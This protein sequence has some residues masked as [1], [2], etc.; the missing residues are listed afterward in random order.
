LP[1]GSFAAGWALGLV[2]PWRAQRARSHVGILLLPISSQ[3]LK[4][5][6]GS[7]MQ[8]WPADG[9]SPI[10]VPVALRRRVPGTGR[11]PASKFQTGKTGWPSPARECVHHSC[12]VARAPVDLRGIRRQPGLMFERV[13]A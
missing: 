10:S 5:L 1:G 8:A 3:L 7:G 6:Q 13:V 11:R 9:F 12:P 2:E 4:N